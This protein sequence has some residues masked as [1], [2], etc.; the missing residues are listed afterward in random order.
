MV[1]CFSTTSTSRLYPMSQ[2]KA[3]PAG[4]R[5]DILRERL[6]YLYARRISVN[7]LIRSLE[8]YSAC[9]DPLVVRRA[10]PGVQSSALSR[11]RLTA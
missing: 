2:K 4:L 8:A 3:S 10:R 1:Y 6:E 7:N 9:D 5:S 11:S